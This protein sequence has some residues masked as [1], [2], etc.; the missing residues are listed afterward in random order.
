MNMKL[1][2]PQW[3]T[4]RSVAN[5]LAALHTLLFSL[6]AARERPVIIQVCRGC[7]AVVQPDLIHESLPHPYSLISAWPAGKTNGAAHRLA[8]E[9]V[10]VTLGVDTHLKD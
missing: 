8:G 1:A 2:Y 5:A 7:A 10:Y 6:T 9:R 3:R 4:Q